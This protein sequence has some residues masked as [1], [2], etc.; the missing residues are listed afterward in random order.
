[1]AKRLLRQLKQ[2]DNPQFVRAVKRLKGLQPLLPC[3][4]AENELARA[5]EMCMSG[6]KM[7]HVVAMA[8]LAQRIFLYQLGLVSALTL[9]HIAALGGSLLG[10]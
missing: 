10:K 4:L 9:L 5:S 3:C 2:W 6:L 7:R 1:M 8:A